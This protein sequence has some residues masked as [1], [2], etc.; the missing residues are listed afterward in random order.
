M[1][2]KIISLELPNT[3]ELKVIET[4][5]VVKGSTAT[6]QPKDA[7]LEGGARVRVPA[8]IQ[9]GEIMRV[10]PHGGVY[11]TGEVTGGIFGVTRCLLRSWR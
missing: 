11:R 6:N 10:N 4:P 3:V 9:I 8:F 5:P 7:E 1:D 2:G